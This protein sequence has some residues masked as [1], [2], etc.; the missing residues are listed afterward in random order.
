L[1]GPLRTMLRGT[2]RLALARALLGPSRGRAASPLL[3]RQ[4]PATFPAHGAPYSTREDAEEEVDAKGAEGA[5]PVD[6]NDKRPFKRFKQKL[7]VKFLMAPHEQKVDD[8]FLRMYYVLYFTMAFLMRSRRNNRYAEYLR[9]LRSDRTATAEVLPG[10]IG[11]KKVRSELANLHVHSHAALAAGVRTHM[12]NVSDELEA[13]RRR[14]LHEAGNPE[15][16]IVTFRNT[17]ASL[18]L[19]LY[20]YDAVVHMDRFKPGPAGLL[21]NQRRRKPLHPRPPASKPPEDK[22]PFLFKRK[23]VVMYEQADAED[24]DTGAEPEDGDGGAAA[25]QTQYR[26]LGTFPNVMPRRQVVAYYRLYLELRADGRLPTDLRDNPYQ[27]MRGFYQHWVSW[28]LSRRKQIAESQ[29]GMY[30]GTMRL[31]ARMVR[32]HETM[33]R[34]R[35]I[36]GVTG[37]NNQRELEDNL[38]KYQTRVLDFYTSTLSRYTGFNDEVYR[39]LQEVNFSK[40]ATPTELF[41]TVWSRI[42]QSKEGIVTW[43]MNKVRRQ[44]MKEEFKQLLKKKLARTS[45]ETAEC[46]KRQLRHYYLIKTI[47]SMSTVGE[48]AQMH[49]SK[50]LGLIRQRMLGLLY[51]MLLPAARLVRHA[52]HQNRTLD[53]VAVAKKVGQHRQPVMATNTTQPQVPKGEIVTKRRMVKNYPVHQ[54]TGAAYLKQLQSYRRNHLM[55]SRSLALNFTPRGHSVPVKGKG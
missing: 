42:F 33:V 6:P 30:S 49:P 19:S 31:A 32:F 37:T 18:A 11:Y 24:D 54:Q 28:S 50:H 34:H 14:M 40:P 22:A 15:E 45:P 5:D 43:R 39:L 26:V 4:A 16:N 1:N 55:R 3:W 2:T 35:L 48:Q 23:H 41:G 38:R 29:K 8:E 12:P 44:Y 10:H 46:E 17:Y 7:H 53:W 27:A 21:L 47:L 9:K 36:Q 51:E 25:K 13:L 20:N 52:Q